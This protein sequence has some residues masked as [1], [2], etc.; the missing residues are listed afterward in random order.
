[1]WLIFEQNFDIKETGQIPGPNFHLSEKVQN[2]HITIFVK[3][4]VFYKKCIIRLCKTLK[5]DGNISVN[6][7]ITSRKKLKEISRFEKKNVDV[8][9]WCVKEK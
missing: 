2:V 6:I 1:M 9:F 4:V 8:N 7:S 3:I 5:M